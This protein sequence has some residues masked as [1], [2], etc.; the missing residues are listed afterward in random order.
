MKN[1]RSILTSLTVCVLCSYTTIFAN[2]PSF[3]EVAIHRIQLKVKTNT[4]KNASTNSPVWVQLTAK[5]DPYYLNNPG[6]DREKGKTDTYDILSSSVRK[7]G[8]IKTIELG[9]SGSDG[10]NFTE[11]ALVVNGRTIYTKKF[12]KAGKWI[13]LGSKKHPKVYKIG[14]KTLR[15]SKNWKY[16]R[17]TERIYRTPLTIP[18]STMISFVESSVGNSLYR[19][20]KISWGKKYGKDFVEAKR[21]SSNT[22]RFDLDLEYE[23]KGL[24]NLEVDV[25]FDLR[26]TCQNGVIVTK[27]I[28]YKSKTKGISKYIADQIE[29]FNDVLLT[30]CSVVPISGSRKNC[31]KGL[32]KIGQLLAFNIDY[33]GKV[34]VNLPNACSKKMRID[35]KGNLHLNT[36]NNNGPITGI[37]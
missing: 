18:L 14:S 16:N 35:N 34:N 5:D 9:I 11:I 33:N 21:I 25:D 27:V 7:I 6:N 4:I 36:P 2:K 22:L 1:L 37:D 28:N 19:F 26:F 3:N 13:D 31:R 17:Y 20:K 10:W 8:D 15:K 24:P 29:D 23:L 12:S 30:T 32:N